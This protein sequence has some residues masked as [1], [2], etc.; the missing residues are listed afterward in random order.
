MIGKFVKKEDNIKLLTTFGY[1]PFVFEKNKHLHSKLINQ[2]SENDEVWVEFEIKPLPDELENIVTTTAEITKIYDS[3]F[4]TWKEKV[5]DVVDRHENN[6][7]PI[8]NFIPGWK[9]RKCVICD[10]YFIADKESDECEKCSI[11]KTLIK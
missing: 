8:G 7:Y 11:N 9:N 5:S 2:L 1:L 3:N 6:S 4:G 10:S